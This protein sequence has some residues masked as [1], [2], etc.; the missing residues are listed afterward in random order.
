MCYGK[1]YLKNSTNECIHE[2]ISKYKT[3][4]ACVASSAYLYEAA[5]MTQTCK[6][7]KLSVF[8]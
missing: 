2:R 6:S 8:L 3:G 4:A 1:T 5:W 7:L